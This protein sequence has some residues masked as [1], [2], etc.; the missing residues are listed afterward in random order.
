MRLLFLCTGNSARSI[1]AE[2]LLR[3]K[4]GS[5]LEIFS[6]GIDPRPCPHPLAL[7][8]LQEEYSVDTIGAYSKSVQELPEQPFDVVI[9]VCDHAR[10]NRLVVCQSVRGTAWRWQQKAFHAHWALSD[11]AAAEGSE[12]ERY[13]HFLTTAH[14]LDRIFNVLTEK[15]FT[16]HVLKERIE[17]I[18]L[19]NFTAENL[20]K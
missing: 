6:A 7:R 4:V 19:S 9:T 20:G 1:I 2:F 14:I 12:W 5:V 16:A 17:N 10:E 18:D 11:P 3:H 13:Q 15:P 8:V